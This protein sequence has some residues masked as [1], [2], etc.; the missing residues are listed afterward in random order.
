MANQI[1]AGIDY[2]LSNP[3][4]CLHPANK[5][6]ALEHCSIHYLTGSK[7][8]EGK[9]LEGRVIGKALPLWTIPEQRYYQITSWALNVMG[10]ANPVAIE[11]Y[12]FA[13]KGRVFNIGE[14]TGLLKYYL[15]KVSKNYTAIPPTVIKKFASGKGNANKDAMHD[16]FVKETGTD[17]MKVYGTTNT[18]SPINDVVDAFYV[19]KY[20]HAAQK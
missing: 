17:L 6:F 19:C 14:N 15:W 1:L 18:N 11:D 4:I 2:S 5:S 9:F 8:G 16:A 10:E 12:A 7:K 3:T 13:A 20:L